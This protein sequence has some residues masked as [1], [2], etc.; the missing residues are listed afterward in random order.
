[1]TTEA[2]EKTC[3][4]TWSK[5][6]DKSW[7]GPYPPYRDVLSGESNHWTYKPEYFNRASIAEV[8]KTVLFE[9]REVESISTCARGLCTT[10]TKEMNRLNPA[11]LLFRQRRMRALMLE[12]EKEINKLLSKTGLA[13]GSSHVL[14]ERES[15]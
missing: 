12:D 14:R 1:M 8:P 3:N 4:Q 15:F 6:P 10:A 13:L 9:E 5:R 2:K 11:I 7:R